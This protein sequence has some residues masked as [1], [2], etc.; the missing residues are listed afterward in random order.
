M[1]NFTLIFLFNSCYQLCIQDNETY[2]TG[3]VA[4]VIAIRSMYVV[5]RQFQVNDI[6]K[7]GIRCIISALLLVIVEGDIILT[8]PVE[9]MIKDSQ[10]RGS[11][12]KRK[13]HKANSLKFWP[14]ARVPYVIDPNLSKYHLLSWLM[15]LCFFNFLSAKQ[16]VIN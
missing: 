3:C 9:D 13:V 7:F 10:L 12:G 16:K 5:V 2:I 6:H 14:A 8:P 1:E 4:F 15:S 11:N